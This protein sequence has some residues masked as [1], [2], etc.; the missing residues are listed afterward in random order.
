MEKLLKKYKDLSIVAKASI[1]FVLCN[2]L[3]KGIMTITVP[4]FT[5]LLTT[6]EYGTYSLYLSWFNI[7]TIFASL[8]LY[9][10]AFNNAMNNIT[11]KEE[12]DRYISSMQGLTTVLTLTLFV[13]FLPLQN[14]W[15]KV[16]GL[17][18][19]A[20]WM[21]LAQLLVDPALLFWQCRQR[22][23]Y[24]YRIMVSVTLLKSL[25]NPILGLIL[26]LC[27]DSDKA[28][29][30]IAS[31]VIV[32]VFFAGTIMVKQFAR[33]RVFYN[34]DNWTY[35][36]GFN[37]PLLPHY[38]S[39]MV[40]N[41]GDRVMI[42]HMAGSTEVGIYSVAYSIGMLTQ[43]FTNALNNSLTPWMY[44]NMNEK[45]YG[46]IR[47]NIN[48]ILL[49]V[50][51]LIAAMLFF[52]PELVR[53]FGSAE[54]YNAIYIVPPV[55]ASVFFIFLYNIV[56]IPQVYYE[57]QKFLAISSIGAA[58]LN[59]VLNAAFIPIFGYYAAGY[60]TLF[61]YLVYT[62]GHYFFSRKIC[63]ENIGSFD[64]FDH[65]TILLIST[66]V[67]A[68]TVGFIFLYQFTIIRYLIAGLLLLI[69]ALQYKKILLLVKTIRS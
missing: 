15:S 20:L 3:Q 32:E 50:A 31:V 57:K 4:L 29:A 41:Q 8:N 23:E 37:I 25:L 42:Q 52:V 18:V 33:G 67:L 45:N 5:R 14:F 28:T 69:L 62:V 53:I 39:G 9:Y 43:L 27:A 46:N 17:S 44:G 59:V 35:A 66:G 10:G 30:R 51:V 64:L 7:L 12:K 13:I 26:V 54:Y 22:F 1:W 65:K 11:D 21:M 38:L 58:I 6:A 19:T 34:K 36:L 68:C 56:A 47:K 16:L 24:K 55:A 2:I 48:A 40:L 49:L 63:M 60:T 61:S